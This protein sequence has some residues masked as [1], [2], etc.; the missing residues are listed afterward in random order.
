MEV[1]VVHEDPSARPHC[2]SKKQ[3][4]RHSLQ[5]SYTAFP[6]FPTHLL[7]VRD[8]DQA[9]PVSLPSPRGFLS[10]LSE[11]AQIGVVPCIGFALPS[12]PWLSHAQEA[13]EFTDLSWIIRWK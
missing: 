3:T 11:P 10:L 5:T 2:L 4:L 13:E 8:G 6:A 9:L 12:C 7:A 1:V